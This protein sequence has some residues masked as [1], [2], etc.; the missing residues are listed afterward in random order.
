MVAVFVDRKPS[1]RVERQAIGTR[2]AVLGN[3]PA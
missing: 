3:A 2:L 1:L